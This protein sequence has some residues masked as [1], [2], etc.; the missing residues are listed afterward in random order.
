MLILNRFPIWTLIGYLQAVSSELWPAAMLKPSPELNL[1]SE[2]CCQKRQTCF[3]TMSVA[4]MQCD[5]YSFGGSWMAQLDQPCSLRPNVNPC[6]C[7][8]AGGSLRFRIGASRAD[9]QTVCGC[10]LHCGQ[11]GVFAA[12]LPEPNRGPDVQK[13]KTQWSRSGEWPTSRAHSQSFPANTQGFRFGLFFYI[14]KAT[15]HLNYFNW[16]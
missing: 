10:A 4:L 12:L 14:P 1:R 11:W 2:Y 3:T 16:M 9:G 13:R 7:V 5:V 6:G 15:P 8:F